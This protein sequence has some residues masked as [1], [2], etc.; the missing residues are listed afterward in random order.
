M[1]KHLRWFGYIEEQGVKMAAISGSERYPCF[2][3]LQSPTL[4]NI[5]TQHAYLISKSFSVAVMF[6]S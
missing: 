1:A 2:S 3:Q 6:K 4:L 5:V